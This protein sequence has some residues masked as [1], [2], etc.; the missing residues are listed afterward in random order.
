[1][2]TIVFIA[3]LSLCITQANAQCCT[4]TSNKL[5]TEKTVQGNAQ[6]VKLRITGMTCAGCSKHVTQ[7]LQEIEGVKKV[8]L[9]YPGDTAIVAF[10]AKKTND[11]ALI[12]A[13]EKIN[14]KAEII[15]EN[16]KKKS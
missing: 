8:N 5:T 13:I 15:N 10:D 4:P 14:Y 7:V 16:T 11:K 12:A 1:M 6:N 2:K 9:E 3:L